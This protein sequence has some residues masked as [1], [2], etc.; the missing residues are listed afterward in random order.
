V[1]G[2][3]LARD[4]FALMHERQLEGLPIVDNEMKVVGYLDRLH[5]VQLWLKYYRVND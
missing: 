2:D 1:T 5:L 3:D 4:A